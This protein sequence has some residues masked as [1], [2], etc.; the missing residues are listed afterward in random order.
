VR[1]V[2]ERGAVTLPA[3]FQLVAAMNG[4]PCG[5]AAST[6]GRCVCDPWIVRRYLRRLSGPLLDRIDLTYEV[7]AHRWRSN[8]PQALPA[9]SA[10]VRERVVAARLFGSRR[11]QGVRNADLA[12]TDLRIQCRLDDEGGSLLAEAAR[13]F[14]LSA[15]ACHQVQRVARTIADLAGARYIRPDD[16]AEGLAYRRRLGSHPSGSLG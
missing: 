7:P 11:G 8:S 10:T 16:V 6:S 14:G 4:C 5:F 9:S 1:I 13:R 12:T 15:R 3:R 2:R